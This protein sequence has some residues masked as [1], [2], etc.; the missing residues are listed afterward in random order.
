MPQY[1]CTEMKWRRA[2]QRM[3]LLFPRLPLQCADFEAG[4][5]VLY[6]QHLSGQNCRRYQTISHRSAEQTVYV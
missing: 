6:V 4:E 3:L 2:A 1:S 5:A